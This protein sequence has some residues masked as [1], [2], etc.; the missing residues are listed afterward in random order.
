[1]ARRK[2]LPESVRAKQTLSERLA[3][4]RAEIFGD[5]GGPE[6][7]RRLGLPIRT[8]Y[9]YEAGVTVPAEVILKIIEL[10]AVE[11]M[12][13]LHGRS[14]KYR[15]GGHES[16][17]ESSVTPVTSV[18][19]LLR[20]ALDMLE[21]GE[22]GSVFGSVRGLFAQGDHPLSESPP[23]HLGY[24]NDAAGSDNSHQSVAH[25]YAAS[26]NEWV[27]AERENRCIRVSGNAMAPVIADGA[28]VAF[29]RTEE[30]PAELDG[31]IVV[32]RS[33][34]QAI[35]RWFHHHGRFALLRASSSAPEAQ[36]I[37]IDLE[38]QP[39]K[40]QFRRVLLINTPH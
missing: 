30:S 9:N 18:E 23:A 15:R 27:E 21:R 25:R 28:F 37:V 33:E 14:P 29:S 13:L 8:W 38:E 16:R 40:W 20:T 36:E 24:G 5:R 39:K 22:G 10:T 32:A 11:P 31:K 3:A 1:M 7:A 34:G 2:T 17:S 6:L 35:V 26:R 12:W 19:G 4:L